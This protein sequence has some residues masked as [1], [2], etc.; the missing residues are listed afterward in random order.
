MSMIHV[1]PIAS[2]NRTVLSSAAYMELAD[3]SDPHVQ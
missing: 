1:R 2:S 3:A